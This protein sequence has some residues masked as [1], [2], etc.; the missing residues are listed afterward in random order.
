MST[1][2]A[3]AL[4]AGIEAESQ[5]LSQSLADTAAQAWQAESETLAAIYGEDVMVATP[6]Q[7]QLRMRLPAEAARLSQNQHQKVSRLHLLS[8]CVCRSL[9]HCIWCN[10]MPCNMVGGISKAVPGGFC[11]VTVPL[12]ASPR[13]PGPSLR[14]L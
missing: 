13:Q 3:L 6:C 11:Q 8:C 4:C 14:W 12:L 1:L 7:T 9:H 5:P 2:L 10:K